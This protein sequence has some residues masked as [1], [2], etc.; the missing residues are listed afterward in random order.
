MINVSKNNDT[1]KITDGEK[2]Y[3]FPSSAICTH[4]D[5]NS[6]SVDIKLKASRKTIISFNY[7]DMYPTQSN[8]ENA[9]KYIGNL[10]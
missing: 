3:C 2:T 7:K 10:I 1:V 5:K 4:A 9:A 8:A 6:E